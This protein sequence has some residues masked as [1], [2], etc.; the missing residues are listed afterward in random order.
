[1]KILSFSILLI[2]T[3]AINVD[4]LSAGGFKGGGRV[5]GGASRG[6][7]GG[8][9]ASMPHMGG[10]GISRPSMPSPRPSVSR[11]SVS[12]PSVSR[13]NIGRPNVPATRPTLPTS[14]PNLP[15]I[16]GGM[17]PSRPATGNRPST[18][19]GN[20]AG[21]RPSTL[22]GNLG[23]NRPSTLPGKLPGTKPS[24]PSL[25]GGGG[26]PSTLPG[27]G[28]RPGTL[29]GNINRPS[30]GDLGDFL[31][32]PGGLNPSN[33]PG[34][35][36]RPSTLPGKLPD[37]AN[38]PTT[39]PGQTRPGGNLAGS[40]RPANRPTTLPARPINLPTGVAG[41]PGMNS[42]PINI[43]NINVGNTL[44]N[45]RPSWANIDNNRI[46]SINNRWQSQVGGL[47]AWATTYPGRVGYWNSWG[48]NVRGHWHGYGNHNR[49]FAGDWWYGH[50]GGVCHWHYYHRFNNYPWNYWWRR[51]TWAVASSWFAWSAPPNVWSQ[52]IYYDYG[53]G[54]NV[55]YE[56]N[57]V[58]I[59]GEPVATSSEFAESA[60]ALAT[61]EP[62]ASD[63]QAEAAEWLPLGTFALST[64]EA[65]IEPTRV[66]QL[67]VDKSGIVSGTLYNRETDQADAIQGR[68][69][70]ETQ[71][72]AFRI[73][74]SETIVAETGIYNL[75][76]DEVP[77]LVHFGTDRVENYVLVRLEQS[78]DSDT[79]NTDQAGE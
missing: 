41:R 8:R 48:N 65:D 38:R 12:Q 40:N 78:E 17:K 15:N 57:N 47:H 75:T 13:P 54:G 25:G 39:L 18:L 22:P 53:T 62:P 72:V 56:N 45:N 10:G 27:V 2:A 30:P 26:R 1:M 52:P 67:A 9:P 16:S 79:E 66:V 29:P 50:P 51:P 55:T 6:G 77:L 14:R 46:S 37:I 61:V 28:N 21:N 60:A 59:S 34:G 42:R 74:E 71:R 43:G 20:I 31:G 76:Q 4:E 49:W 58:Y 36:N 63:E 19:P 70:K 5:G 23:G 32:I 11:P 68:V 33:R 73:G 3:L 64:S 69:D 35:I 44:I 7:G 24:F